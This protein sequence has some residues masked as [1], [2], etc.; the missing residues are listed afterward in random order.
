M[1]M[2]QVAAYSISLLKLIS[3]NRQHHELNFRNSAGE[4]SALIAIQLSASG[5]K[6]SK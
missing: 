6:L 1:I 3:I 2:D 4:F 5:V